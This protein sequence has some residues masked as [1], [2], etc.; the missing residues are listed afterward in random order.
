M[1]ETHSRP[2]DTSLSDDIELANLEDIAVTPNPKL[3][4]NGHIGNGFQ[5]SYDSYD[6]DDGDG[7]GNRALLHDED[8]TSETGIAPDSSTIW[9]QV[10]SIVIEAAPTLL[11]TTISL[12]FTGKLLDRVSHWKAMTRVNELIMIIPVVLNLKGNLEMNLSA[13][14]GTAANM[15]DLD[16]RKQ[17]NTLILGNLSLLQVQATVVSFVA[18]FVAFVLS[19]LL[20]NS[21]PPVQTAP[22]NSSISITNLDSTL[23]LIRRAIP[24][25]RIPHP[26]RPTYDGRPKSGLLEYTM[27]VS[28]AMSATCLSGILQGSFMCCLIVMCRRFGRDPDNIAPPIASCLG[29]LV[30][31]TLIGL[32]SSLL[33]NFV[34]T[35][36]PLILA[37]LVVCFATACFVMT[38]R[39]RAVKDLLKQGWSPLFGAMII[40]S[41]T[42]IV[43]DMFVSRYEG[44]AL[45]AIV[46]SGLPG[47]VGSIFASRLSTALHTKLLATLPDSHC[48]IDRSPSEPSARLVM[49]TLLL[50]TLPVELIFLGILHGLGWLQLP[51]LFVISAVIFFC[52]AVHSSILVILSAH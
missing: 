38:Y 37:I 13:R 43:L 20:P 18:A 7:D 25:S 19:L 6:D 29:D 50:V 17:R 24:N 46:I 36:L 11:L 10:K 2:S 8:R 34:N 48:R 26:T 52:C 1:A 35:P 23:F 9:D 51:I 16:E 30:T 15:G 45:L 4:P 12:L 49:I 40:S 42:G 32:V 5:Y 14:L 39:N 27:V 3:H 31:L 21:F 47:A 33:I 41:G 44:F 28:T 22:S